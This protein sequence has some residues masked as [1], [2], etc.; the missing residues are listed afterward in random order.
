MR[1]TAVRA[2]LNPRNI[3]YFYQPSY[4]VQ[5]A[6]ALLVFAIGIPGGNYLERQEQNRMSRFRDKSALY[7][8]EKGPDDE[9]S[10]GDKEYIWQFSKM[11][12]SW[13]W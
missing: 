10:W 4:K 5:I 2:G 12:R 7:G 13:W 1:L 8:T 9:P 6:Q 3:N 11:P